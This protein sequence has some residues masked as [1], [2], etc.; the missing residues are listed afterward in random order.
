MQWT[1]VV[2]S[3]LAATLLSL[4]VPS[5]RGVPM[6]IRGIDEGRVSGFGLNVGG[7]FERLRSPAFW[8]LAVLFFALFFAASRLGHSVLR[9]FLFW[10]P[11][12]SVAMLGRVICG[13][14][15]YVFMR[16]RGHRREPDHRGV[17]SVT[18]YCNSNF[19]RH[20]QRLAFH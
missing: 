17:L 19:L 7:L 1:K 10:T 11:A 18:R 2:L 15:A 20:C 8:V 3:A 13:L 9:L 5:L 6:I 14:F 16:S 4:L 12:L